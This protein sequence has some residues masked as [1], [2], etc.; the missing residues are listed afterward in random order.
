MLDPVLSFIPP[1]QDST[2]GDEV[3]FQNHNLALL[4]S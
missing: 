1:L 2:C 3:F 4:G